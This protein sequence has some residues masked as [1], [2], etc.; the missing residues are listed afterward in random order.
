MPILT[1]T[2]ILEPETDGS[3][4]I[5]CPA[6]PGCVA[7]GKIRLDAIN[8]IKE[9]IYE[10]AKAWAEDDLNPPIDSIDIIADEI[11]EI[12]LERGKENLPLSIETVEIKVE[13]DGIEQKETPS[14]AS[15]PLTLMVKESPLN[16]DLAPGALRALVRHSGMTLNEFKSYITH[17]KLFS[18]SL[19]SQEMTLE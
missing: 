10:S 4:S 9:A 17:E 14:D 6:M 13:F 15:G 19:K 12:M 7:Q 18:A 3:Y 5:H 2:V 16:G 8:N 1:Y 11:F